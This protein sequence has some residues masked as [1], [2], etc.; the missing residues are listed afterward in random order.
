MRA[1][2]EADFGLVRAIVQME[3]LIVIRNDFTR[4]DEIAVD[5]DV[6]MARTPPRFPS[7]LN[8]ELLDAHSHVEG[9]RHDGLICRLP[10][11]HQNWCS[12]FSTA[13]ARGQNRDQPEADDKQKQLG[14]S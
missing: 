9:G 7:R 3:M 10:K 11:E 6:K 8:L 2:R 1:R 13:A 5:E 12:R 4:R 14:P